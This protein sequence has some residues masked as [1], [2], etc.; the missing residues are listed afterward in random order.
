MSA[1]AAPPDA[2]EETPAAPPPPD[3]VTQTLSA[4]KP[5]LRAIGGGTLLPLALARAIAFTLA[6]R[7]GRAALD[8]DA[9]AAR[10]AARVAGAGGRAGRDRRHARGRPARR[11]PPPA[12]RGRR[13]GA[14][15]GADADGRPRARRARPARR[16]ERAGRRHLARDLRPAR[17]ARALPR[18]RR[19]GAHGDPA[20]RRR[21]SSCS[22]PSWRSGRGA[23]RLGFPGAA[24]LVLV[25]L[26]VVPVIAIGFGV[27]FLSGAAFTL[28][29][30][31]F[32]RLEKLRRPDAAGAA[33]LAARGD[34]RRA[35]RRARA[36]PRHAVV[37][38]RDVGAGDVL[39]E[40]DVV[41]LGPL[42]RRAQLAARRPRAAA[43]ARPPA[44]VLEGREPRRVRRARLAPRAGQ[45]RRPGAPREPARA[46]RRDAA[47]QG[48]D[49]QPAHGPVHHRG[50]R[51]RA[52][53]SRA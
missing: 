37:R 40:V 20:R 12:R 21:R 9:R 30:V 10:A 52:A 35:G 45:L 4:P 50:L 44:R 19:L 14:A 26:Y 32:L 53:R 41:Q 22:P 13:A 51:L 24:L 18:P 34:A 17:R 23:N 38:L 8:V 16:L 43:R 11:P 3:A 46:A 39:V 15:D 47:H 5:A 28:L 48:L 27:E 33:A 49:P 29:M 42:L 1:T 6:R 31:A 2:P 36:Q 7:L 25:A